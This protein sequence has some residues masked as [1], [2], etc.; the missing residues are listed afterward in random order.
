[1]V[2]ASEIIRALGMSPKAW[3]NLTTKLRNADDTLSKSL[4]DIG[5]RYTVKR[6]GKTQRSYLAR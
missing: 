1:M 6:T 2:S 5:V 3:N 4:A